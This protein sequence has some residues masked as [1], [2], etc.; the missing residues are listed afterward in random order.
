M[1]IFPC[2]QCGKCCKNI[3]LSKETIFLDRGDGICKYFNTKDY[4]CSIYEKRPEICRI[5][6]QYQNH[7]KKIYSWS[8]F[9]EINL[10]VC[11]ALPEN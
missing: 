7:Y 9:V 10:Q 5:N 11:N 6:N 1:N 2:T 8:D 4:L 3:S